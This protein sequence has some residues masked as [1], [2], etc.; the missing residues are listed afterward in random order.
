ML[1]PANEFSLTVQLELFSGRF[2]ESKTLVY[3]VEVI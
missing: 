3:F 1:K 2:L